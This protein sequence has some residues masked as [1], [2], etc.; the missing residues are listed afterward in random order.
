MA[1][2]KRNKSQVIREML[3]ADPNLSVK[4]IVI[5]M[6]E[7]RMKVRPSL[8]Y[9]VKSR[10]RLKKRQAA[11]G[12]VAKVMPNGD[13]LPTILKVKGLA[14]EVGGLA[15]LKALVEALE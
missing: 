15:K 7:K 11:R 3:T 4:N 5:A 10:M 13:P 1:K 2:R 6:A 12:R 14:A 9:F 8:V